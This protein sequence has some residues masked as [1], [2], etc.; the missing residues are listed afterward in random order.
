MI[1]IDTLHIDTITVLKK[2][3]VC[4]KSFPKVVYEMKSL[5]TLLVD[6]NGVGIERLDK[7]VARLTK[8]ENINLLKTALV[9]LPPEI[10]RLQNLKALYVNWGRL[11][12]V[13]P[14]IGLLQN[15]EHLDL[16][17]N[18]LTSLPTEMS[19][20]NKLKTLRLAANPISEPEQQRIKS[21][22]PNCHVQFA[23][24]K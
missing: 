12:N 17:G 16:S 2:R 9:S 3:H 18:E 13:P 10:G 19:R 20:L 6:G 24:K 1:G 8:L 15:L 7:D 21:L 23:Y 14:E 5:E 11:S 22:L 4:I